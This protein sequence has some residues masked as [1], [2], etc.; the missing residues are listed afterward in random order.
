MAQDQGLGHEI[1]RVRRRYVSLMEE[2][3]EALEAAAVWEVAGRTLCWHVVLHGTL[4]PDIDIEVRPDAIIVRAA[5]GSRLR[6]TVLPVPRPYKASRPV[7]RFSSGVLHV[8]L[9]RGSA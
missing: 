6:Q 7:L 8:R 2:V 1:E 5:T 9:R 3:S 4:E